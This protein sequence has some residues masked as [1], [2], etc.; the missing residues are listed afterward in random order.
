MRPSPAW[1]DERFARPPEEALTPALRDSAQRKGAPM[2]A[3][4]IVDSSVLLNIMDVPDR[5]QHKH[6]VLN[7]LGVLIEAGDHLFIPMA[8]RSAS[9]SRR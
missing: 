2:S 7:R 4:V 6:D 5:N 3:I 1:R 9:T 8:A